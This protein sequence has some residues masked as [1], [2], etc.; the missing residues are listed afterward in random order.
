ME[1][2]DADNFVELSNGTNT[3]ALQ[4][5]LEDH[6][7]IESIKEKDSNSS[8]SNT[9]ELVDIAELN[10]LNELKASDS[11]KLQNTD[12]VNV[13]TSPV[14]TKSNE[15]KD[16][17]ENDVVPDLLME[18]E[19]EELN[20]PDE[21]TPEAVTCNSSIN[22]V[23]IIEATTEI[24]ETAS[25]GCAHKT[26]MTDHEYGKSSTSTSSHSNSKD[27]P[28]SSSKIGPLVAADNTQ[29]PDRENNRRKMIVFVHIAP[30]GESSVTKNK[31]YVCGLCSFCKRERCSSCF[32]CKQS[33]LGRDSEVWNLIRMKVDDFNKCEITCEQI[34]N[35][36]AYKSLIAPYLYI[37]YDVGEQPS[38]M[39]EE[40][41]PNR[42]SEVEALCYP[43][44]IHSC[45]SDRVCAIL[46][47]DD[48]MKA[49]KEEQNSK[50]N[51][52]IK[53]LSAVAKPQ[54]KTDDKVVVTP[55]AQPSNREA[56]TE[57]KE[58]QRRRVRAVSSSTSSSSDT[59]FSPNHYAQR[60][61]NAKERT[62]WSQRKRE[63]KRSSSYKAALQKTYSSEEESS[64]IGEK[65]Q[66]K[67]KE[68][69]EDDDGKGDE[70]DDETSSDGYENILEAS[71]EDLKLMQETEI[72]EAIRLGTLKSRT[73]LRP[74]MFSQTFQMKVGRFLAEGGSLKPLSDRLDLSLDTL[75]L[76]RRQ[77]EHNRIAERERKI[78]K[79]KLK[80][81]RRKKSQREKEFREKGG[82]SSEV[83]SVTREILEQVKQISADAEHVASPRVALTEIPRLPNPRE[84]FVA[85]KKLVHTVTST[86]QHKIVSS[87][88]LRPIAPSKCDQDSKPKS[89]ASLIENIHIY[90]KGA[91]DVSEEES[92]FDDDVIPKPVMQD[93]LPFLC[94]DCR[95]IFRDSILLQS[96]LYKCPKRLKPIMGF[97]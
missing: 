31:K 30:D 56:V 60:T 38:P 54:V 4:Q 35:C 25:S 2:R 86:G 40:V 93:S 75:R 51:N 21:T 83:S 80:T 48:V 78:K 52:K 6:Q 85:K 42:I 1:S 24:I 91:S 50:M 27:G 59:E 29:S 44:P 68:K 23:N 58:R 9:C 57:S 97:S 77:H 94:N 33:S 84:P 74:E 14:S 36:Q 64:D 13:V 90:D 67:E 7:S 89:E 41:K 39:G 20:A 69:E 45:V 10:V 65:E 47:I 82:N 8:N 96:H 92:D 19:V 26:P 76:W 43:L 15:F 63:T 62:R 71:M 72:G 79:R 49:L 16:N 11:S 32:S 28:E 88:T 70:G 73:R 95:E 66:E 61:I 12:S 34:Q 81:Q 87:D 55:L 5:D 22:S 37:K 53:R 18:C 17:V 46:R 3:S